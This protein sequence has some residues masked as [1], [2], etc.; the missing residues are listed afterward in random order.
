MS[1]SRYFLFC[2]LIVVVLKFQAR[3]LCIEDTEKKQNQM[4]YKIMESS[5]INSLYIHINRHLTKIHI[6]PHLYT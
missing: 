4:M 1:A 2:F 5:E 3:Y 6:I